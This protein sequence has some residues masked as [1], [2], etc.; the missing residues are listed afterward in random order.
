MTWR[1]SKKFTDIPPYNHAE[2]QVSLYNPLAKDLTC[3]LLFNHKQ[4]AIGSLARNSKHEN[5]IATMQ[6][7]PSYQGGKYGG[8]ITNFSNVN[9]YQLSV[10][11][12]E[13]S[14][15]THSALVAYYHVGSSENQYGCYIGNGEYNT[16]GWY[17]QHNN[18]TNRDE[19]NLSQQTSTGRKTLTSS[20]GSINTNAWNLLGFAIQHGGSG[21][22]YVNG[23]EVGSYASSPTF[24]G[25]YTAGADNFY[26]G[27]Y[28]HGVN[29][30]LNG[31][32]AF[33]YHWNRYVRADEFLSLQQAP[34]QI[35]ESRKI[36]V[37]AEAAPVGGMTA[38][39]L[40]LTGVGI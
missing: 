28:E 19:L 40:G 17:F 33:V 25:T 39:T 27:R 26:I 14:D 24:S 6:G 18:A 37:P 34:F 2:V 38:G 20:G 5:D 4:S 11:D 23:R 3:A 9:Y 16:A 35:F 31:V 29:P 36:W 30:S 13:G 10:T 1:R 21:K 32:L 12:I 15:N 7:T 22:F 8:G